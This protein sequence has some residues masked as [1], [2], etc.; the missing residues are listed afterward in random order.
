MTELGLWPFQQLLYNV[1][2]SIIMGLS[3]VADEQIE[4][5]AVTCS[6]LRSWVLIFW[7]KITERFL[8]Q[9]FQYSTYSLLSVTYKVLPQ[10]LFH[11]MVRAA[12]LSW[13]RNVPPLFWMMTLRLGLKE[14]PLFIIKSANLLILNQ[15][16]NGLPCTKG[17]KG[18]TFHI[19][20]VEKLSLMSFLLAHINQTFFFWGGGVCNLSDLFTIWSS[21]RKT[22]AWIF[23]LSS[24]F[25]PFSTQ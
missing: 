9:C 23:I 16:F 10:N 5:Q 13:T 2:E 15:A 7:L 22:G 17:V 12:L 6:H 21:H 14:L 20:C 3:L 19:F 24:A 8:F 25:F 18:I 1:P 11:W 4:Y